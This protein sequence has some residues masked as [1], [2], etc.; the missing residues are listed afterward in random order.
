MILQKEIVL[1]VTIHS[2]IHQGPALSRE[3]ACPNLSS[4]PTHPEIK[5]QLHRRPAL[6]HPSRR[7]RQQ[8]TGAGLQLRF[9]EPGLC[10]LHPTFTPHNAHHQTH[11]ATVSISHVG[12]LRPQK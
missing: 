10:L 6:Q 4:L 1:M 9:M 8:E 11:I 2:F 3:A 7:G 5:W 12:K